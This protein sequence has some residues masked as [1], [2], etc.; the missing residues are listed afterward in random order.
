MSTQRTPPQTPLVAATAMLTRS[1]SDRNISASTRAESADA[2]NVIHRYK[3]S[4]CETDFDLDVMTEMR[5]LFSEL[6]TQQDKKF[7]ALQTTVSTIS[8]QNEEISASAILISQLYDDMKVKLDT[9]ERERNT[10][11]AYIQSLEERIDS[12][13]NR[14]RRSCIE[15][16][17]IPSNKTETKDD[18][19]KMVVETGKV[20]QVPIQTSDI[21][22]AYRTYTKS[23]QGPIV[24]DFVNVILKEK[25]LSSV[26]KYNTEN[27][28]RLNT[29]VLQFDGPSK[30]I[31]I[32][33]SLSLKFKKIFYMARD[34]A[35]AHDYRYCWS[36]HGKVYLRKKEG[37]PLHRIDCEAHLS[38]LIE[39][40]K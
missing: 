10:H 7:E 22:D 37:S 3:R 28:S 20:I 4:R 23:Y 1:E 6:K 34:F 2:L 33:E 36:S 19:T 13:E 32:S 16:R 39:N 24:I 30:P 9:L 17:N 5:K 40:D 35:K 14:N 27:K 31:F 8:K 15:F 18:F 11:L 21:R 29:T 25:F 26:K 12:L 38:Q